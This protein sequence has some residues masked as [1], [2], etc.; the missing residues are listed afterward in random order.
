MPEELEG[1]TEVISWNRVDAPTEE[2]PGD[3]ADDLAPA[4][5][6]FL[7]EELDRINATLDRVPDDAPDLPLARSLRQEAQDRYLAGDLSEAVLLLRDL[8]RVLTGLDQSR[9]R[10]PLAAPWDESVEELFDR[11]QARASAMVRPVAATDE[12]D[13]GDVPVAVRGRQ[14]SSRLASSNRDAASA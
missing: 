6:S 12:E 5:R 10:V 7:E 1:P 3:A 4:V 9:K 2:F 14:K 11:V 8:R 13:E